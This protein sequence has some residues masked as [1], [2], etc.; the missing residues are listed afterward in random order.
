MERTTTLLLIDDEP[1]VLEM[2]AYVLRAVGYRVKTAISAEEGLEL[3]CRSRIDGLIS[4][5]CLDGL[6][7]FGIAAIAQRHHPVLPVMLISGSS[8]QQIEIEA[9]KRGYTF[10]HKPIPLDHFVDTAMRLFPAPSRQSR[11][12]HSD[13]DFPATWSHAA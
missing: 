1:L 9:A 8:T 6:D 5:V 11:E 10:V 4:D 3:L 7:G 12:E 13:H 2:F